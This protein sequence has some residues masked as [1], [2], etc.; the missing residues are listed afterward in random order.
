[1]IE[2]VVQYAVRTPHLPSENDFRLWAEAA[3]TD[4]AGDVAITIRLVDE[5]EGRDL[6]RRYGDKDYAT[7]VL[8]FPADVPAIINLPDLGDI[9]LCAPVV[10]REAREQLKKVKDH[11]AH[12][13]IHAILH[14]RG[15]D[16]EEQEQALVMESAEIDILNTL[17]ISNPY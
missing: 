2:L 3:L 7:N 15:H 14:L 10:A 17:G 4:Y 9:V 16:H 6:N 5:A 8:S 11:W 12:L 13:V 1:M